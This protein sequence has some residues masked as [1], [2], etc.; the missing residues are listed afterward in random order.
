MR[1]L[2]FKNTGSY[3]QVRTEDGKLY[4]C[5]IKGNFRLKN[6][7]STNPIAIGDIVEFDMPNDGLGLIS[8]IKDRKNYIVRKPYNLAK[9]LQINAANLDQALLIITINYPETSTT[10]IDRLYATCEAYRVPAKLIINKLDGYVA[11]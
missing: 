3:Y 9:Q 2:V 8:V 10:F 7:K 1:G 4:D 6:I 5:K 11:E